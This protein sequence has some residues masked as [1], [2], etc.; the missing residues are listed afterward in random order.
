MAQAGAI[1]RDSR[2][3]STN[4]D[5]NSSDDEQIQGF[6]GT[7][8]ISRVSRQ[9][10]NNDLPAIELPEEFTPG[11]FASS[12]YGMGGRAS[13]SIKDIQYDASGSSGVEL[14]E[15]LN[16]GS[17]VLHQAK[18]RFSKK[19]VAIFS[20]VL[21]AVSILALVVFILSLDQAYEEAIVCSSS[22]LCDNG[23]LCR[24]KADAA[25]I[26][27]LSCICAAGYTGEQCEIDVDECESN[28]CANGGTCATEADE[29]N[30][31]NCACVPGFAGSDCRDDVDECLSRPCL[32]YSQ[33]SQQ[34]DAFSCV[35][36]SGFQGEICADV[37]P[38]IR[39]FELTIPCQDNG[40]LTRPDPAVLVSLLAD[41]L[42]I[43]PET[44]LNFNLEPNTAR[45]R[46][47][48]SFEL[49]T[50]TVQQ[51]GTIVRSMTTGGALPSGKLLLCFAR[52]LPMALKVSR[53]CARLEGRCH[54]SGRLRF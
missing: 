6:Q 35:C 15:P 39:P 41:S 25:G 42:I 34:A 43:R 2:Q 46:D 28:P 22:S 17:R 10:G 54:H 29:P 37:V 7:G 12:F 53:C 30:E 49:S 3:T 52:T 14:E 51:Q 44:I 1:P 5:A 23:G 26:V 4:G 24:R 11:N 31:F 20:A 21:C 8:S 47:R 48:I 45:V 40:C 13:S 27:T 19:Q 18:R 16:S 33:C 9:A 36:R 38:V 32:H 50:E